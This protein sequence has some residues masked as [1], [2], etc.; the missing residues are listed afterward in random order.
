M[1][2]GLQFNLTRELPIQRV[3]CGVRSLVFH[4]MLGNPKSPLCGRQLTCT[5]MHQGKSNG[6]VRNFQISGSIRE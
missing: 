3:A 2:V 5:I 6:A 1:M 4:A